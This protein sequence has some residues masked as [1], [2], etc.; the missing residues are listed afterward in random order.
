MVETEQRV[1]L[2]ALQ[3]MK[4]TTVGTEILC[5]VTTTKSHVARAC[6]ITSRKAK[7]PWTMTSI[8]VN[9]FSEDEELLT[10]QMMSWTNH[11][12][13]RYWFGRS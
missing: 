9:T 3:I 2:V 6:C 13:V 4:D 12:S 10:L 8:L 5:A 1:P 11:V 7:S